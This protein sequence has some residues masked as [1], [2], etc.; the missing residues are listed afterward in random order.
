MTIQSSV[1]DK[2]LVVQGEASK[3]ETAPPEMLR[4][5]DQQME[6]RADGGLYFMDQI[7]VSLVGS[8]MDEAHASSEDLSLLGN[9]RIL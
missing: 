7:W 3:V 5:L 9:E 2:I 6:K 8:V 1:K 4:V